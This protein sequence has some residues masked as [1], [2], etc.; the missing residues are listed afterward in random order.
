MAA[1]EGSGATGNSKRVWHGSAKH[2]L[3]RQQRDARFGS[4]SGWIGEVY[5]ESGWIGEVYS[6]SGWTDRLETA[7]GSMAGSGRTPGLGGRAT[8][9]LGRRLEAR[10]GRDQRARR[11]RRSVALGNLWDDEGL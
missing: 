1:G 8:Q 5:S 7:R 4:E 2:A 9:T 6:E 10:C 11:A 3:N